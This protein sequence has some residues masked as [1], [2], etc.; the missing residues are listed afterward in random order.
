MSGWGGEVLQKRPITG[1]QDTS[2]PLH[3]RLL[4]RNQATVHRGLLRYMINKG[5]NFEMR[6]QV[7]SRAK[8]NS[9]V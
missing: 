8:L 4:R 9:V 2:H 5:E 7:A 3:I 1:P 6:A